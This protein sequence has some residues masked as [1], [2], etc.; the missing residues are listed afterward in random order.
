MLTSTRCAYLCRT[1][2]AQRLPYDINAELASTKFTCLCRIPLN[3]EYI[4]HFLQ[5]N[6]T[7]NEFMCSL[8]VLEV[9][10]SHLSYNSK[11]VVAYSVP[12]AFSV[13]VSSRMHRCLL[14]PCTRQPG[15]QSDSLAGDLPAA[16]CGYHI[17]LR[18]EVAAVYNCPSVFPYLC[19]NIY[20]CI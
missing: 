4:Y 10:C 7:A 16:W 3:I 11:H 14:V 18:G 8:G 5:G 15:S 20:I 6:H 12:G 1:T 9:A 19:I 13:F 17:S 2:H